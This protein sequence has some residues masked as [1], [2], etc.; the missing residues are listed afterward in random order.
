[1]DE[2][3]G[4]VA[5]VTG[6]GRGIG[7][8][9]A[10]ALASLGARVAAN[11]INPINLEETVGL[12]RQAGGEAREYVFDV[13]KRMPVE[14][15]VSQVVEHFGRI[16]ILVCHASVAPEASILGMDEWEFHR[17]LDVNLGGP[18]FCIQLVGRVMRELGGG[19]MV[20][21]ISGQAHG[22][23]SPGHAAQVASQAGL[24]GLTRCAAS[25]LSGYNIRLNAVCGA[26]HE[27]EP[28]RMEKIDPTEMNHWRQAHPRLRL[29]ARAALASLAV[30]LC[31]PVAATISGQVF[32]L[33]VAGTDQE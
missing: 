24:V 28:F 3:T 32:A 20:V 9:V 6:A 15:M 18:F 17:T 13:A 5:L 30:Y 1:M 7:R 23:A 29:G 4:K 33:A 11:D 14:G 12:I 22:E 2:F 10:V 21:I 26:I 25:E 16:D 8:E 19:A 27:L 31:S